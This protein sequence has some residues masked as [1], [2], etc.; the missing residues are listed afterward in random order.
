MQLRKSGMSVM[1]RAAVGL[2]LAAVL[3]V[4]GMATASALSVFFGVAGL[5]TLLAL[6]MVGAGVG[7]GLGGGATLLRVDAIPSRPALLAIG[8]GFCLVGFAGAWAGFQIGGQITAIQDA[9]CVGVCGY[10][11][12]PRT[13]MALGA[14]LLCNAAALAFNLA[15][16]ARAGGWRRPRFRL[17]TPAVGGP[18]EAERRR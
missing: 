9:N 3:S 17:D 8:L 13:Y 10:L 12:K 18:G 5:P 4:I 1:V 14:A 7:A 2:P 16:E 6:L 15:W 11:F